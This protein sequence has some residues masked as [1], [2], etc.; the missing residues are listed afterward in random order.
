MNNNKLRKIKIKH[1]EVSL[2][3][4]FLVMTMTWINDQK[5]YTPIDKQNVAYQN[6]VTSQNPM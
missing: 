2:V 4:F 3:S 5:Y 6:E 1:K